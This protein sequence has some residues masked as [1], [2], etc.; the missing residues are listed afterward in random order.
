M[1]AVIGNRCVNCSTLYP[2]STGP[3]ICPKCGERQIGT[4]RVI[5]G[6]QEVVYDYSKIT[7]TK[8]QL[9]GRTDRTIW[10]FREFL[11]VQDPKSIVSLGEGGTPL[12][13]CRNLEALWGVKNLYVKNEAMNPTGS[14]KDRATS[15]M[16]SMAK[17]L[18]VKRLTIAGHGPTLAAVLEKIAQQ[19]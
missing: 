7:V 13:R 10:R 4:V 19:R 18:G 9:A 11:P 12:L 17:E 14:F 3:F 6:L 16:F 1:S 2:I 5:V 15:V 8:R